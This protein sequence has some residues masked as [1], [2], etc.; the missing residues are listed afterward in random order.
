MKRRPSL[1]HLYLF[2]DS[3]FSQKALLNVIAQNTNT[4]LKINKLPIKT[5]IRP[6]NKRN[7]VNEEV[8]LRQFN[9]TSSIPEF[10]MQS[11]SFRVSRRRA[12]VSIY[13][14]NDKSIL[15][16]TKGSKKRCTRNFAR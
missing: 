2:F 3:I 11:I 9:F 1:F 8:P 15:K 10:S 14:L 6:T 7:K 5:V 12:E 13:L 16:Q 4:R